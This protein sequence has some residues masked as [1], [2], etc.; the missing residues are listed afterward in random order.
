MLQI[1]L[2]RIK[3]V[4]M[5]THIFTLLVA[6]ALSSSVFA[7]GVVNNGATIVIESGTH[8]V[9]SNG[10]YL[11]QTNTT[12]GAI[13]IDGV[14]YVS[15]DFTNNATGGNVFIN[16]DTD[17]EVVFN[18]SGIQTI[19]GSGNFINFEK[20]TVKANSDTRLSEGYAMTTNG[21]LTVESN[22]DFTLLSPSG[23][24]A[25][26]SLITGT[27]SGDVTGT[28]NINVERYLNVN[29][30][31]QYISIPMDNQNSSILSEDPNP[32]YT[33]PNFYNYDE[34][35]DAPTDPSGT[36]YADWADLGAAWT[37]VPAGTMNH[38][39]QGF[40]FYHTNTD[41]DLTF[42][43]AAS[44][45]NHAANYTPALTYNLNDGNGGYF[46]GWNFIGNPYPCAIDWTAL[47]TVNVD[48]TVYLWDSD[49]A[50][51]GGASYPGN[52]VYYNG[53]STDNVSYADVAVNSD[54][55][56][57]HIPAMQGFFVKTNGSAPSITI[58]ASAREHNS[59][60]MFKKASSEKE[61][62]EYLKLRVES[63]VF[64]DETVVRFLNE[65]DAE[66]DGDFDAY[67]MFPWNDAIP[68]IYSV[69]MSDLPLAI[70]SLPVSDIGQTVPLGFKTG[71]AGEYTINVTEFNFP[72]TKVFF[73]DTQEDITIDL[74]EED[75][76]TFN[77]DGGDSRTRFCLFVQKSATDT[78]EADFE[79]LNELKIW[80]ANKDIH[81][82]LAQM[83]EHST[84]ELYNL[85]GEKVLFKNINAEH[86]IINANVPAGTYIAKVYQNGK[87]KT[88]KVV[89]R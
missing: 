79:A 15:G 58:P 39:G 34:S 25:T 67:K 13:D 48:A 62:F 26:A 69:T 55:N 50:S 47:S 78:D 61:S 80:S 70:N 3:Y 72:N 88:E 11:N 63:G 85:L 76:Y 16:T 31:Y 14:M 24:G 41:V 53:A 43:S 45:L 18:G 5:K 30:R 64:S 59:N 19:S 77:Y 89:L 38:T 74:Q 65:A 46:D 20:V 21:V 27:G 8:F 32:G 37:S 87:A 6:L 71:E 56:A 49:A 10:N 40:A 12:D 60:D 22:G 35:F 7:Q 66:F 52:Y 82:S 2:N 9:I 54:A 81:V 68:M 29:Q 33:N 23:P 28:G 75:S 73:T 84:F 1:K 36:N 86:T 83:P 4:I 42:S 17:G 51:V 57:Q 44:D